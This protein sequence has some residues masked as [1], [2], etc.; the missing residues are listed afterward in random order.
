M[1]R[2]RGFDPSSARMPALDGLRGLAIL[3]V[4]AF[5]FRWIFLNRTDLFS[6]L[7]FQGLGFGWMGV[8][9]FFV[10]SGFLITGILLDSRGSPSYFRA[11]Y[12]RRFL[13]IFPLYYLA[14][15]V[16]LGVG[17]A[18]LRAFHHPY[19]WQAMN[20]LW[21]VFYIANWQPGFHGALDPMLGHFWSLCIEEQFY[22]VWPALLWLTPKRWLPL[23]PILLAAFAL[24]IRILLLH[25]GKSDETNEAVYRLTIT[26]MD[27]LALGA[28]VA[29]GARCFR[30]QGL[31]LSI[32][33]LA[34]VGLIGIIAV[35]IVQQ[36]VTGARSPMNSVGFS[37][38]A[39]LFAAFV[40]AGATATGP[41][42]AVLTWKPL[43]VAG[44]FSY[45]MYIFHV[46]LDFLLQ[47]RFDGIANKLPLGA[48]LALRSFYVI[49][50][51]AVMFGVGWLSWNLFEKRLLSLKRYLPYLSEQIQSDKISAVPGL[52]SQA[53]AVGRQAAPTR[54]DDA[55]SVQRG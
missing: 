28:W 38:L 15:L 16:V 43:T 51:I 6:R 4:M 54:L 37:C 31:R 49:S 17:P 39:M 55:R 5:H 53:A 18:L 46:P 33:I 34:S 32:R 26:R 47:P 20:P 14:L 29:I 48:N 19:L 13:R 42:K 11:F 10:L 3:I 25:S 7:M 12:G 22:I 24:L 8:D 52:R 35:T 40:Y 23:L 41:L 36:G 2:E 1:N 9:L 21:Y 27:G 30:S 45:A 44:T 50:M